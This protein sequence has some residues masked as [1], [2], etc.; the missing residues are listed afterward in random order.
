MACRRWDVAPTRFLLVVSIA[1]Q[2]MSL[3]RR[4]RPGSTYAMQRRYVVS[5]SRFGIGSQRNTNCTPLGLHRVA[6]KVGGGWPQGA[7]WKSR[8]RVGWTWQG[9]PEAPIAHR[10]LWLDGLEPGLNRGGNVD[11]FAR[12][13]YVHGIGNEMTL[14]RP[15]SHGCI[16]LS[17]TD[18]L[19]LYDLLPVGTL[20]WI[21]V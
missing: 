10:I 13:I 8:R 6:R 7:V 19:P 15:A 12:Y 20:I 3:W 17:A 16:H 1:Q 2:S 18:I 11:T 4:G 21:E 9:R 14:G 5:T